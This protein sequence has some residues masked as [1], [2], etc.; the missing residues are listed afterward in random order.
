MLGLNLKLRSPASVSGS[1]KTLIAR[2]I[3]AAYDFVVRDFFANYQRWCPQ[4]VELE[5]SSGTPVHPGVRARQVTLDR[6]IK[7]E[8]TFEIVDVEEPRRL[9]LE[10]LSEPFRSTYQFDSA[11]T[12]GTELT[13]QFEMRE[14]ELSMR[15]FAKL[16]RAALQEGAEQTVENLK[17]ILEGGAPAA[18]AAPS[19]QAS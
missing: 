2:S 17:F 5:P 7:S 12:E 14:L 11:P 10:G 3:D 9:T 4:V 19:A 8:S 16:I 1:A 13:F 6:G 15:P 18:D